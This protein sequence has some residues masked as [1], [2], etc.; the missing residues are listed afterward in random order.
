MSLAAKTPVGL[1]EDTATRYQE[2]HSHCKDSLPKMNPRRA[3]TAR[4]PARAPWAAQGGDERFG[5][6]RENLS[7]MPTFQ[8][9]C[10][11]GDGVNKNV[12]DY[13]ALVA[14]LVH[15]AAQG[16][17]RVCVQTSSNL[18]V[19]QVNCKWS[20][21][22]ETLQPLLSRVRACI[23]E[24]EARAGIVIVEHIHRKY[25]QESKS[26]ANAAMMT[27]TSTDWRAGATVDMD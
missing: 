14:V 25:N 2:R 8:A 18:V 26:L 6:P 9:R 1:I 12:A 19:N 24:I 15:A 3:S 4:R 7:G 20:C 22:A 11:L 17:N 27:K 5:L 16:Y 13:L 21:R 23:G 10:H